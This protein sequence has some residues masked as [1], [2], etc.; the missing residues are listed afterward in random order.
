MRLLRATILV[1]GVAASVWGQSAGGVPAQETRTLAD[2]EKQ[3]RDVLCGKREFAFQQVLTHAHLEASRAG[4]DT[5]STYDIVVSYDPQRYDAAYAGRY[6]LSFIDQFIIWARR[7]ALYSRSTPWHWGKF[8]L[9]ELST[10]RQGWIAMRDARGLE[11]LPAPGR[12]LPRTEA[13][14]PRW[15]DLVASMDNRTDL[16]AMGR[17]IRL[18][19]Q[20]W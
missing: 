3:I 4:P 8:Y 1:L 12:A 10:G 11:R 20:E 15:L 14:R 9:R 18:L 16:R 2:Q 6:P 7:L 5:A 17:W 19:H 13:A